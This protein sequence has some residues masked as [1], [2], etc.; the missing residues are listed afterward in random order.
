MSYS[1]T[2]TQSL[3]SHIISQ[4]MENDVERV[5]VQEEAVNDDRFL[6]DRFF[7]S[8]REAKRELTRDVAWDGNVKECP[9]DVRIS[10]WQ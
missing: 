7:N 9:C 1:L 2:D 5:I 8:P 4:N 3:V 10:R 6:F